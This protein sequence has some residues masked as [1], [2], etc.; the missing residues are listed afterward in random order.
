MTTQVTVSINQ[1]IWWD[2]HQALVDAKDNV[3]DLLEMIDCHSPSKIDKCM[4]D[5]YEKEIR[6]LNSLLEYSSNNGG[7]PF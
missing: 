6:T 3:L 7:V 1:N 4:R 2:N 5:V